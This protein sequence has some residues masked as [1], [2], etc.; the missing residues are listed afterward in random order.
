[1]FIDYDWLEPICFWDWKLEKNRDTFVF[2]Q[3]W[4]LLSWKYFDFKQ[5]SINTKVSNYFWNLDQ[6]LLMDQNLEMS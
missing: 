6:L 1:M 5:S 4:S 2:I 3:F